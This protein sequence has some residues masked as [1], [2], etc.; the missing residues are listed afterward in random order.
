MATKRKYEKGPEITSVQALMEEIKRDKWVFFGKK[1]LNPRFIL[2]MPL[3]AIVQRMAYH[4]VYEAVLVK[5]KNQK[6]IYCGACSS[7]QKKP[8][9]HE[10]PACRA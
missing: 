4:D 9:F 2:N 1:P 5:V 10:P 8:I 7:A 6:D 3:M